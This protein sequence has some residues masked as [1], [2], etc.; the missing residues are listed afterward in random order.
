MCLDGAEGSSIFGSAIGGSLLSGIGNGRESAG[1]IRKRG[2][3]FGEGISSVGAA[4]EP[5][6]GARRYDIG[7]EPQYEQLSDGDAGSEECNYAETTIE[8]FPSVGIWEVRK[9]EEDCPL[10]KPRC[11]Q[12]FKDR[13]NILEATQ[14]ASA[15]GANVVSYS[16]A[17]AASIEF[18]LLYSNPDSKT[19]P[20]GFTLKINVDGIKYHFEPNKT[21]NDPEIE[22][23]DEAQ[24]QTSLV[25]DVTTATSG[26]FDHLTFAHL[27]LGKQINALAGSRVPG[28]AAETTGIVFLCFVTT[29]KI[30]KATYEEYKK[31]EPVKM[32]I[33]HWW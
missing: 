26:A 2:G 12:L 29:I 10:S 30:K 3:F 28:S 9:D 25:P 33:P 7:V 18:A 24:C 5:I 31:G 17:A 14:R 1:V 32:D 13:Q 22:S 21:D 8:L 27:T 11:A 20:T 6:H 4:L 19:V 16:A 23:Y 15:I